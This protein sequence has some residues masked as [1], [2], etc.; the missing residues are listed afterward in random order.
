LIFLNK[1]IKIVV[2][3]VKKL[4]INVQNREK[5]NAALA[6][7]QHK[8]SARILDADFI[9]EAVRQSETRL[10]KILPRCHWKGLSLSV[11]KSPFRIASS[12]N[13]IPMATFV[14]V[15]RHSS[16]WFITETTRDNTREGERDVLIKGLEMKAEELSAFLS[17]TIGA[18]ELEGYY[19]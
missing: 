6:V 17:R 9:E 2:R 7:S 18:F 11:T 13:G 12:Y 14:T 8:C 1:V 16:G 10:Q 15:T 5:I 3:L 19:D 4:K